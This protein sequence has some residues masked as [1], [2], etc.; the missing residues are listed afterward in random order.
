MS[1]RFPW[2]QGSRVACARSFPRP[3]PRLW[4]ALL[5]KQPSYCGCLPAGG[6]AA[7]QFPAARGG[8]GVSLLNSA[9]QMLEARKP[10]GR[11]NKAPPRA[12]PP[13]SVLWALEPGFHQ[14]GN[15]G[16][17][18]LPSE[19]R[20][21]V[22]ELI[23]KRT[24]SYKCYKAFYVIVCTG[25]AANRAGGFPPLCHSLALVLLSRGEGQTSPHAGFCRRCLMS[26][27]MHR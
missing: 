13:G 7:L 20:L 5:R 8:A 26:A 12:G 23:F 16:R 10:Q 25:Q 17:N 18:R 24:H 11:T 15:C 2:E 21:S 19:G 14:R 6:A 1:P 27:A 9:E 3:G 4:S 22:L